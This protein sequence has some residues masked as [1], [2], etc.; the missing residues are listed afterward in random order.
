[1]FAVREFPLPKRRK[2]YF[3]HN[4]TCFESHSVYLVPSF[5]KFFQKKLLKKL[6][7]KLTRDAK[8]MLLKFREI[9]YLGGKRI[10]KEKFQAIA[11]LN[12]CH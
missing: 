2:M 4:P 1:M 8:V 9:F 10:C 7:K 12:E 3:M 11:N 6:Q 5:L